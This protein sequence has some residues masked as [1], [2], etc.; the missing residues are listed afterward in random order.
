MVLCL[1]V[2]GVAPALAV[3]EKPCCTDDTLHQGATNTPQPA[4]PKPHQCHGTRE[5]QSKDAI[6]F[7]H[8]IPKIEAYSPE[9]KSLIPISLTYFRNNS[10]GNIKLHSA[11]T[12]CDCVEEQS[13]S[14]FGQSAFSPGFTRVEKP[15]L[16]DFFQDSPD[17]VLSQKSHSGFLSIKSQSTGTV[18]LTPLYLKNL[19]LLI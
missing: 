1:L 13:D 16:F 10:S 2:Q 5:V 11:P 19:S 17:G 6:N 14:A 3:C 18:L 4:S 8:G 12:S 9:N 7:H 15:Q